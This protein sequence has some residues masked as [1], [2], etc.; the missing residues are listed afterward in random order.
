VEICSAGGVL[1]GGCGR[2]T[3]EGARAGWMDA[4]G[5]ISRAPK[6]RKKE[7]DAKLAMG[8]LQLDD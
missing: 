3:G 7:N 2:G 1:H 8:F 5:S 4:V 6:S